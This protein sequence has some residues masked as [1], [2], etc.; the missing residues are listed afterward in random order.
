MTD[1]ALPDRPGLT[2]T[3]P[4]VT[5]PW[6]AI[7]GQ[8]DAVARLSAALDRPVHAYLFVGPRGSGLRKAAATFAGELLARRSTSDEAARRHRLLAGREQHPDVVVI[9]PEGRGLLVEEAARIVHEASRSPIEAAIKVIVCDRFHTAEAPV[10]PKLLKAIEEPPPSTVFV[11]LAENVPAEHV[12]IASRCLR[13]DFQRLTSNEIARQLRAD[14]IADER[15]DELAEAAAG[16][17]DRARLLATDERFAARRD[18]WRS[19]PGR[20]DG[21]GAAIAVIVDELRSLIDDAQAPLAARHEVEID[22]LAQLEAERGTRGSGRRTVEQRQRRELRTL[23][24]DELRY[25]LATL[26]DVYRSRL[27]TEPERAARS[28]A[29]IAALGPVLSRNPTESLQL[30]ALL[31]DLSG[32]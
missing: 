1:L 17:L 9:E 26:A 2:A 13:I 28:M 18:A 6:A 19:M 5:D 10:A 16:D 15:A 24:D 30:Q 7:P 25:G 20:L 3:D 21:T 31:V 27:A 23:R 32:L 14:G 29:R 4:A 22:A 12:T 11:L 8:P